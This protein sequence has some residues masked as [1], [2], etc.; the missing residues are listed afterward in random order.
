[1]KSLFAELAAVLNAQAA[2]YEQ[3]LA[4]SNEE[5]EAL[6]GHRPD[7]VIDIVRRKETFLLQVKTLDESRRLLCS[8]IAADWKLPASTLTVREIIDRISGTAEATA[9]ADAREHL[10]TCVAS[11]REVNDA[12]ARV[13]Q[14]GIEVVR[15]IVQGV[16][17]TTPPAT[18]A[19][20]PWAA[21]GVAT[22]S[23]ALT[24]S[25]RH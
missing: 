12:N 4:L 6:S 9:L 22:K 10:L 13:C 17:Q 2:L 8:R 19:N 20:N 5:R 1:M 3:V 25:P 18:K 11:L 14:S 24:T 21:Y 15:R 16:A 23:P 7:R